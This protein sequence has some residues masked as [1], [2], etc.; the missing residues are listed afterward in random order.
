MWVESDEG[1]GS[2]FCFTGRFGLGH[3]VRSPSGN[4][5]RLLEVGRLLKVCSFACHNELSAP[6]R[7]TA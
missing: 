2:S 6:R 3:T 5:M 4:S 1:K 7:R